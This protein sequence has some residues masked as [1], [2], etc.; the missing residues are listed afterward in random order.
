[1]GVATALDRDGCRRTRLIASR[2]P[3]LETHTVQLVRT[4]AFFDSERER[5]LVCRIVPFRVLS[6]DVVCRL[7]GKDV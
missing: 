6:R 5:F 1:M 4:C 3:D 7:G 2:I